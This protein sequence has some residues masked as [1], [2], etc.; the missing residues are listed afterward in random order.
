MK[1][2]LV[3]LVVLWALSL[4]PSFVHAQSAHHAPLTVKVPFEFVVGNQTFPAGSYK[5]E[6]LLNSI[7]GKDAIDVLVV[8][9]TEGR[10]YQA[11]VTGV[12]GSPEPNNARLVFT[13]TADYVFLAEVWEPGKKAGCRLQRGKGQ[14]QIAERENE[15]VTLI[16]SADQ[17]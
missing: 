13:R 7:P 17:R 15:Q 1:N 5:F 3:S 2:N 9:S 14:A 11:I 12:I 6:S 16:A 4:C 10:H 8:R